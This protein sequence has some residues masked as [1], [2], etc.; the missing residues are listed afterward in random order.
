MSEQNSI[1]IVGGFSEIIELAEACGK[2]I[3]GVL[4]RDSGGNY[5]GYPLLGGDHDAEA[6]LRDFPGVP[7]VVSPDVPAIR[8]KLVDFYRD[9]GFSFANL[10]HPQA[11]IS[12]S[13]IV[14]E[15]VIIQ[16]GVNVSA[17]SKIGDFVKLNTLCNIMHDADIGN[18]TTVA[19][20]AVVLG[21]VTIGSHCYLGGNCT[22]LP[23]RIVASEAMV[24]AGAVVTRDVAAGQT[25]AGVPARPLKQ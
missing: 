19:P 6:V 1:I 13:A 3:A 2:T 24:G 5:R 22:I 10:I 14:G 7:L 20:N 18:F 25:V 17:D 11:M 16:Y 23:E 15:G 4:D 12:P 21:R 8:K 9:L